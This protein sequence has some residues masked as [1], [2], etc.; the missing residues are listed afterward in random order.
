MLVRIVD[1]QVDVQVAVRHGGA[2]GR[3]VSAVTHADAAGADLHDR[4]LLA[5]FADVLQ[6]VETEAN[7]LR[8]ISPAAHAEMVAD[9]HVQRAALPEAIAD[10]GTQLKRPGRNGVTNKG[11]SDACDIPKVAVHPDD[12]IRAIVRVRDVTLNNVPD[13]HV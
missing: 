4:E 2:N 13:R 8:R 5:R 7:M 6:E 1:E 9:D 12:G 10:H 3:S 11:K